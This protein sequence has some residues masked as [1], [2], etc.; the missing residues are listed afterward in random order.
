MSLQNEP[1]AQ[2]PGAR[3]TNS[4]PMTP[5]DVVRLA[6]FI[7]FF[8]GHSFILNLCQLAVCPWLKLLSP[9]ANRKFNQQVEHWFCLLLLSATSVWAPTKLVLTGDRNLVEQTEKDISESSS[10]TAT[11]NKGASE[12]SWFLSAAEHGCMMISN[13]QTYFDWIIIWILSYFQSC[14]GYVKIILKAELKKVPIFGWGMQFLDFIFLKRKWS[15][16]EKIFAAHTQRIINHDDPTWLLIFPEGTVICNKRTAIS[17]KYAEKMGLR[18]PEHTLLPRVSGS[19]VCLS[20]LRTRVP[21]LYDLTIGYEGLK[22][23]DIPEDEYGLVSMYGKRVYPREVHIHVKRY[24]T[25]EIPEDEAGFTEWMYRVFV[26]KDERM[27]KF[28][29]LGHFPHD[30]SEDSTIPPD[31]PLL[32]VKRDAKVNNL[33]LEFAFMWVQFFA[34]LIPARYV[35]GHVLSAFFSAFI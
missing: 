5:L 8:V 34:I 22:K 35:F 9:R 12:H 4:S 23:G 2:T 21:Y 30:S 31:Q 13:H 20:K 26:E 29:K 15:E 19:R 17:D 1:Q 10:R 18:R 25:S 3:R 6:A 24:P 32:Q 16:D 7:I 14:D 28:Y 33:P 11:S 27:G